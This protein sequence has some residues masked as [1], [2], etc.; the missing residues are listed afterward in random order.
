MLRRLLNDA[1]ADPALDRQIGAR[2]LAALARVLLDAG[3]AT[4][5]ASLLAR[6]EA[7]GDAPDTVESLRARLRLLEA[8]TAAGGRAGAEAALAKDP[9][10][11][12]ARYALGAALVAAGETEAALE[13]FLDLASAPRKPRAD[14]ARRAMLA[15]FDQL[16]TDDEM[17]RDFRRRLQI[18]S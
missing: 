8:A 4:D 11:R 12:E 13:Q 2:V 16:G 15:I 9:T 17:A 3:D 7:R 14:D 1:D 6:L 18:V 10:D 5:A